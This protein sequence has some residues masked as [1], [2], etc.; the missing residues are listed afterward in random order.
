MFFFVPYRG[1]PRSGERADRVSRKNGERPARRAGPDFERS[2]DSA[3][4]KSALDFVA[5]QG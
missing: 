3:A 4:K 1:E 2:R 5:K